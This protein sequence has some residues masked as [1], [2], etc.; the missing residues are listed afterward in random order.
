MYGPISNERGD[1]LDEFIV[2]QGLMVENVGVT[3]TFQAR[4]QASNIATFIDVTLTR[5]LNDRI[6]NWRVDCDFN[7]SDH[8]TLLFELVVDLICVDNDIRLWESTDWVL[9]CSELDKNKKNLFIPELIN[10][11]KLEK[12]LTKFYNQINKAL[13]IASP[14]VTPSPKN[15]D[16]LWLSLIHIPSPRD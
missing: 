6:R 1:A 5:R 7:G 4:R 15:R 12:M 8:N 16:F 10:E 9:F 2:G 13:D 11:K 14:K 3:P